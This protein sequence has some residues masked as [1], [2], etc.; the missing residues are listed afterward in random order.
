MKKRTR[1]KVGQVV[2]EKHGGRFVRITKML[3]SGYFWA[4]YFKG[5]VRFTVLPINIRSLN[6]R[7]KGN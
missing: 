2:C 6:L 5:G 1:F 3:K 4:E 7:E